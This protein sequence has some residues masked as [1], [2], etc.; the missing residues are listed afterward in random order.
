MPRHPFRPVRLSR[1]QRWRM[2]QLL[3]RERVLRKGVKIITAAHARAKRLDAWAFS[4]LEHQSLLRP[5]ERES[6]LAFRFRAG[7]MINDLPEPFL[8]R[9]KKMFLLQQKKWQAEEAQIKVAEKRLVLKYGLK[10]VR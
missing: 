10:R 8:S 3:Q 5:A 2:R 1:F 7:M 4:F 6:R 9:A